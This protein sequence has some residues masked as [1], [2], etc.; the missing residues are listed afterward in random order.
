VAGGEVSGKKDAG[1]DCADLGKFKEALFPRQCTKLKSMTRGVAKEN[2]K[3]KSGFFYFFFF[4]FNS[5]HI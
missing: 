1:E 5:G 4:F 2:A 3:G